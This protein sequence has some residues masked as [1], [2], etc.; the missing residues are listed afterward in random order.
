[1]SIYVILY[2]LLMKRHMSEAPDTGATG[3]EGVRD[4]NAPHYIF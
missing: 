2:F 4:T 3:E 1:M